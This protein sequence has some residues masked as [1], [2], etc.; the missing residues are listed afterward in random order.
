[1]IPLF[2]LVSQN[3]KNIITYHENVKPSFLLHL[4][5]KSRTFS[6]ALRNNTNK[7]EMDRDQNNDKNILLFFYDHVD[8]KKTIL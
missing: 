2:L 6:P 3:E 8:N 1:M 4:D 5:S 7:K